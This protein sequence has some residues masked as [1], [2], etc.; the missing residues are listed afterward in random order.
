MNTKKRTLARALLE[1]GADMTMHATIHELALRDIEILEER[2]PAR[3]AVRDDRLDAIGADDSGP[4]TRWENAMDHA[5]TR[6]W[7]RPYAARLD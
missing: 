6:I 4:A 3:A 1:H 5:D 2:P 7:I